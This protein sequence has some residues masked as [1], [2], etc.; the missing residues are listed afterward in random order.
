M[1][2]MSTTVTNAL[3]ALLEP[4]ENRPL[5]LTRDEIAE[6]KR[7]SAFGEDLNRLQGAERNPVRERLNTLW[8]L[9]QVT[10]EEFVSL[11]GEIGRRGLFRTM[12]KDI[13][14]DSR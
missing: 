11:V 6:R 1:I 9:G 2:Q 8:C 7:G 3:D 12:D 13:S 5:R 4:F 14:T 10:H